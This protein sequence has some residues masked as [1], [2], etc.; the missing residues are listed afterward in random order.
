MW[1]CKFIGVKYPHIDIFDSVIKLWLVVSVLV[2]LLMSVSSC[3]FPVSTP[4]KPPNPRLISGGGSPTWTPLLPSEPTAITPS[5]AALTSTPPSPSLTPTFSFGTWPPPYLGNP[6]PAQ[7]TAIP[8]AF[9]PLSGKETVNFLLVGSDRRALSFRTDTLVVVSFR[10]HD[11]SVSLISI[12]RDLYVYIPGWKM[13]R[14]NSAYQHGE[15]TSYPGGGAQLLKDT[16]G[17]NLGI[18]IDHI[19]L[20]EFDGFRQI[21]DTLGGIDVPLV[22]AF[23]DWHLIDPTKSDQYKDNWALFTIGPGV[24]H[25][26]GDLALWYARSRMRSSDFDRGR[27]QQEVLRA[28]FNRG[29]HLNV[30]Q[31]LPELYSQLSHTVITDLSLDNLLELTP[32]AYNLSLPHIRSYY[33]NKSYVVGWRT[34]AGAAVLLPN[35]NAIQQLVSEAM[36]PPD[37]NETTNWSTTIEI[38]NGTNTANMDVLAAERLHYS[39]FETTLSSS[40]HQENTQT[41]L[42]DFTPDQDAHQRAK[43]LYSL[44]IPPANLISN[45]NPESPSAYRLIL[46]TDFNPCFDPAHLIH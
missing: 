38:W 15:L 17:Y 2:L 35:Q 44:G 26:D 13:Q 10:P 6:G 28:I 40:D 41:L 46:G 3:N 9:P 22:C 27:R 25:M 18:H 5:P 30:I 36:S 39:G 1:K 29:T 12:P 8:A 7:V 32:M 33:I 11:Q 37:E 45:P 16:V 31:N 43:L 4:T 24:V 21:L 19:A 34:P 14:I 23:T 42:Y 20:V